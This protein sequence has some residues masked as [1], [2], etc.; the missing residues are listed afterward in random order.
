LENLSKVFAGNVVAVNNLTL[1]IQDGEFVILLG[2]CGCGKT[3]TL[4]MIAGLERET[5]GSIRFDDDTVNW[6]PTHKRDVAMVF[7]SYALYPNMRTYDNMAFGL[8]IRGTPKAEIEKRVRDVAEMLGIVALYGR[9]PAQ[10]S[11]GQRQRVALGRAIVRQPRVFLLD[12]LLR[13]VACQRL[14]MFFD[15]RRT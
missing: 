9:R 3:T 4:Q 1:H 7:Q 2:P 11:G 6:Q 14:L 15:S 8:K 10:L 5:S 12:V 13:N